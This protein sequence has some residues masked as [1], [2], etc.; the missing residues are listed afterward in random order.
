MLLQDI[1]YNDSHCECR[2]HFNPGWNVCLHSRDCLYSSREWMYMLIYRE[3]ET[4]YL[5][6]TESLRLLLLFLNNNN[7]SKR[8]Y[9]DSWSNDICLRS[10]LWIVWAWE[11]WFSLKHRSASFR[12]SRKN[13]NEIQISKHAE[14]I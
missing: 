14:F 13:Q 5:T 1:I 2:L 10:K 3:S 7:Q 6:H 9:L 11:I 8:C 4:I 12:S